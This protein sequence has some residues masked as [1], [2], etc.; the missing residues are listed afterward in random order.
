LNALR[1]GKENKKQTFLGGAAVLALAVAIVK[2]LG[3]F[4]K[5]PLNRLIGDEGFGYFN[6]AYDIYSV[7]LMVST[8]GL[9][10]AMSRMISEAKTLGRT[11]QIERIFRVSLTVF[12]I[13]GVVGTAG[14][15]LLCR[16]LAALMSQEQSW[17][18]ILCLSPA[19]LFICLISAERG[20]FQGQSNMVPTSVSQV[21]EAVCKLVVGLTLAYILNKATG[22]MSYAAGG[23]ILGVTIGTVISVVYLS[24]KR[25]KAAAELHGECLDPTVETPKATARKLL[26]IALPITIGAAGL[27]L[28]T[29]VDAAVYMAQLKGPAGFASEEADKLKGIYNFAQTIFNLPCAFITPLTVSAIPAITEQLTL[30]RRRRANTVAES[31]TRVMSLVA[32]PCTIGLAVLSEPIM[33]LLGGYD[34]RRLELASALMSILAFC[35]FFNSFVLVMHAILQ[36]HGFVYI[37]VINMVVGGLAKVLINFILVGNPKINIVGV[38]VGTVIC[39]MLISMLDLI[40]LR[41]V[42]K[43]PPRLIPNVIKPALAALV[44]GVAAFALNALSAAIGLPLVLRTA[45]SILGAGAVYVL[46]VLALKVIT[47][48]DCALL[49]KGDKIAKLLRV[50]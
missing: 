47:R 28:I 19:V 41:R 5:I 25:R 26:S 15:A 34:G 33:Q 11:K 16:Q 49:P 6:T 17:F 2:V 10:V 35:V 21:M 4:Y 8:T 18:A 31:A 38:P 14:M 44:M 36:A 3:A 7:L 46:L 39:Y 27:Q 32:M 9:P 23:A 30:R 50:Q 13:L 42:L 24:L 12:L 45:V 43:N 20:F 1:I 48:E 29:T 22:L 37:P 40:A